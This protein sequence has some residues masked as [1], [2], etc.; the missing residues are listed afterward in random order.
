MEVKY[1]LRQSAIIDLKDIAVY[2][3]KKF[4]KKQRDEYLRGLEARF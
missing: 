4:G 1:L 2:T 3:L